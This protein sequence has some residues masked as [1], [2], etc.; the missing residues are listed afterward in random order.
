MS[1]LPDWLSYA[2]DRLKFRIS[3]EHFVVHYALRNPR[4]GP[5]QGC[6]GMRDQRW[7]GF[8]V[9]QL[10]FAYRKLAARRGRENGPLRNGNGKTPVFLLDQ[11]SPCVGS[12][13]M[14]PIRDRSAGGRFIPMLVLPARPDFGDPGLWAEY[15]RSCVAHELMHAFNFNQRPL[16]PSPDYS[17]SALLIA[18]WRWLNEGLAVAAEDEL[19]PGT[20]QWLA[21]AQRYADTPELSLGAADG[22]HSVFLVRYLDRRFSRKLGSLFTDG[23]WVDSSGTTLSALQYL[24]KNLPEKSDV[25]CSADPDVEDVFA[26]GFCR[27]AWFAHDPGR[28]AYEPKVVEHFGGRALT[29][30]WQLPAGDSLLKEQ[31]IPSLACRYYLISARRKLETLS[32]TITPERNATELK[33]ELVPLATDGI[34]RGTGRVVPFR[35]A[36]VDHG[37]LNCVSSSNCELANQLPKARAWLLVVTNCASPKDHSFGLLSNMPMAAEYRLRVTGS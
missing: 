37:R 33:A 30:A 23:L 7:V 15:F 13:F 11:N 18:N 26:S 28:D 27:D 6:D 5:G 14:E 2:K 34:S 8:C 17:T 32:V 10:E 1:N 36:D 9:D 31:V 3:S 24:A 16:L 29:H 25:F 12:P 35:R 21:Y 20:G 22:Y 19:F 4:S